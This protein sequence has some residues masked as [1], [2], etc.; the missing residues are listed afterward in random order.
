MASSAHRPPAS[1]GAGRALLATAALAAL[2]FV[3]GL[4]RADRLAADGVVYDVAARQLWR[5][6]TIGRQALV[7]A[8][9]WPPLPI[10]LRLPAAAFAVAGDV[11]PFPS[12]AVSAISGAAALVLLW[13]ALGRWGAGWARAPVALA[14]A[15]HPFFLAE[16]LGGGNGPLALC[17]TLLAAAGLADWIADRS[18]RALV[19]LAAGAALLTG[20]S[21]DLIPWVAALFAMLL[22]DLAFGRFARG[23]RGAALWLAALP[24]AWVAGLWILA[25]WLIMG[26]PLYFLRGLRNAAAL[27]PL[28][29][30]APFPFSPRDAAAAGLALAAAGAAAARGRRAGAFLGLLAAAPPAIAFALSAG[31]LLWSPSPLLFVAAPLALLAAA[32]HAQAAPRPGAARA[33]AAV[34]ALALTAAA[35]AR[36]PERSLHAPERAAFAALAD[37]RGRWLPR[38]EARVRAR[39]PYSKVFVAGYDGLALLG[40]APSDTFVPTLD[41]D[42]GA[43]ERDY[44]GNRL[45]LLVRRPERRGALDA[46]HWKYPRIYELGSRHTLYD[47]DWG[48]WRLFE[49]V[50]PRPGGAR[51]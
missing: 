38:I 31:G 40:A 1:P 13:R 44:A 8:A 24:A 27:S 46:I 14:V 23:Q 7:G 29:H 35:V 4:G 3:I 36:L 5:N 10:L 21:L 51:P 34:A 18:L 32:W 22:L 2:F 47:S 49:I 45:Y 42:F 9:E 37:Q 43:A 50:Q 41:F 11:G 33:A 16:T 25:N 28:P 30:P 15:A 19:R 17:G 12:L 26:D 48:D 6:T 20:S 39:S